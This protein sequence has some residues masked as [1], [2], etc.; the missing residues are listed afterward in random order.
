MREKPRGET[1]VMTLKPKYSQECV[2]FFFQAA[3]SYIIN[4]GSKIFMVR[5]ILKRNWPICTIWNII[6]VEG[7]LHLKNIMNM[8][9]H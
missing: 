2:C 1:S 4:V 5:I 7:N 8:N 9:F 3:N 6:D